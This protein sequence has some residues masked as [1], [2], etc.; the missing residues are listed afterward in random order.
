MLVS[1]KEVELENKQ[2]AVAHAAKGGK[3]ETLLFLVQH[4]CEPGTLNE[5]V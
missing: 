5:E 3:L 1:D 4:N 2:Q